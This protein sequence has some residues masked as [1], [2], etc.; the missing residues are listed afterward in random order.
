MTNVKSQVWC[1]EKCKSQVW[2]DKKCKSQVWCDEK[3]KDHVLLT[4]YNIFRQ[5]NESTKRIF[6][7]FCLSIFILI[8]KWNWAGQKK[9]K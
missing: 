5:K 6:V 7:L 2:C 4:F 3:C 8:I 9:V 1:D